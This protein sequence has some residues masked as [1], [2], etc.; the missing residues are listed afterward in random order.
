M[1]CFEISSIP[2]AGLNIPGNSIVKITQNININNINQFIKLKGNN[3]IIDGQNYEII[4]SVADYE[5]FINNSIVH[6]NCNNCIIKNI[7]I[8]NNNGSLAQYGGWLLQ[9]SF[10]TYLDNCHFLINNCSSNGVITLNSGGICGQFL[11]YGSKNSTIIFNK[12][13][14]TGPI[15]AYCGG[16]IANHNVKYSD[17]C[18][19]KFKNCYSKG[20]FDGAINSYGI[21]GPALFKHSTNCELSIENCMVL[22][23]IDSYKST[24]DMYYKIDDIGT[25]N[26]NAK[27]YNCYS[28]IQSN[29]VG[30]TYIISYFPSDD[31]A[32][33]T[34]ASELDGKLNDYNNRGADRKN[35]YMSTQWNVNYAN[36]SIGYNN[37][38]TSIEYTNEDIW[39]K[40]LSPWQLLDDNTVTVCSESN[41]PYLRFWKG[42]LY[43]DLYFNEFRK[44]PMGILKD[45]LS[46]DF[47]YITE[48]LHK[49]YNDGSTNLRIDD[50]GTTFD[51]IE[52]KNLNYLKVNTSPYCNYLFPGNYLDES[53]SINLQKNI[54]YSI[55]SD[56]NFYAIK[57]LYKVTVDNDKIYLNGLQELPIEMAD[58]ILFDLTDISNNNKDFKITTIDGSV[59]STEVTEI[60]VDGIVKFIIFN[61]NGHNDLKFGIDNSNCLITNNN[62]ELNFLDINFNGNDL[63][64]YNTMLNLSNF[65]IYNDT[66]QTSIYKYQTYPNSII[67]INYDLKAS[68]EFYINVNE[69]YIYFVGNM[70]ISGNF[71]N[72]KIYY[73][74]NQIENLSFDP[75]KYKF[76]LIKFNN[77]KKLEFENYTDADNNE[78]H[79]RFMIDSIKIKTDLDLTE[80]DD[81]NYIEYYQNISPKFPC[82]LEVVKGCTNINSANYN[83]N[84]NFNEGCT[85]CTVNV[86]ESYDINSVVDDG[87]CIINANV[88]SINSNGFINKVSSKKYINGDNIAISKNGNVLIS[89]IDNNLQYENENI[90]II[91]TEVSKEIINHEN[92][93]IKLYTFRSDLD[94]Y[95]DAQSGFSNQIF[96]WTT[97]DDNGIISAMNNNWLEN[98]NSD[99]PTTLSILKTT[100]LP[101][102]ILSFRWKVISEQ[103]DDDSL[104]I[105]IAPN[106]Q[107]NISDI[108]YRPLS[109]VYY[110]YINGDTDWAT[111]TIDLT[112]FKYFFKNGAVNDSDRLEIIWSFST[113]AS[114]SIPSL[115]KGYLDNISYTG[116]VIDTDKV[117]KLEIISDIDESLDFNIS[118]STGKL[119]INQTKSC[120]QSELVWLSGPGQYNDTN[121]IN[122]TLNNP[123]PASINWG[124]GWLVEDT[125]QAS[126]LLLGAGGMIDSK[127]ETFLNRTI[128][129]RYNKYTHL[130]NYDLYFIFDKTKPGKGYAAFTSEIYFN[131]PFKL[132]AK[133]KNSSEEKYV[134][135]FCWVYEHDRRSFNFLNT[136]D[137]FGFNTAE[138]PWI[139]PRLPIVFKNEDTEGYT[140]INH[141]S[142][143]IPDKYFY[144][145]D[146]VDD[147]GVRKADW[148]VELI[149]NSSYT[150]VE[151]MGRLVFWYLNSDSISNENMSNIL[152]EDG[153]ILKLAISNPE[154]CEEV[155]FEEE[156]IGSFGK[157]V[158][159]NINPSFVKMS[160]QLIVINRSNLNLLTNLPSEND[161]L[162]DGFSIKNNISNIV[163]NYVNN[164]DSGSS[165]FTVYFSTNDTYVSAYNSET[166]NGNGNNLFSEDAESDL[167]ASK[168]NIF[169]ILEDSTYLPGCTNS[170]AT[171][172]NDNAND[173]D[174]TCIFNSFCEDP[175]ACNYKKLGE[176]KYIVDCAGICDGNAYKDDHKNCITD[177]YV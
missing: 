94:Y 90:K 126:R 62:D 159:W 107:F 132:Y 85:G 144:G 131:L 77:I 36:S 48:H 24:I 129:G 21:C 171:N 68:I 4:I 147:S 63:S 13:Y 112:Q 169:I 52:L 127:Y 116:T 26:N 79:R 44:M 27:I 146:E 18:N 17:N 118:N 173:D 111:V 25:N 141:D 20:N 155:D 165:D 69:F 87:S 133:K 117:F 157:Y 174:G 12:C 145:L 5:G 6:F 16:I 32:V 38:S 104:S 2:E 106:R 160:D 81:S 124:S 115:N 88:S 167:L 30:N 14:S 98:T 153:S 33:H 84:A 119:N 137:I 142:E 108:G 89:T 163:K 101:D 3:I 103:T 10:G 47:C 149:L 139:Y 39:N 7:K 82:Y 55:T 105:S 150:S 86:S 78:S 166:I 170:N 135:C 114:Q 72:A 177:K 1:R 92:S 100:V 120:H 130:N 29:T 8:K 152:P 50:S 91:L 113:N 46:I 122:F 42:E 175:E 158:I 99:I 164:L 9:S 143:L 51:S 49:Y 83:S 65:K 43:F 31:I 121:S 125:R 140:S 148:G 162:F 97:S 96:E 95:L 15:G 35:N 60:E 110:Q 40:D 53:N 138:S 154:T 22:G 93:Q 59:L 41:L 61:N 156:I 70:P 34:S 58:Q 19:L 123:I 128:L 76:Y 28:L 73:G 109:S 168:G 161:S 75:L 134:E 37:D 102:G 74:D 66:N 172:Y 67:P 176:C 23:K 71:P 57:N 64:S 11:L 136:T 151:V 54:K 56:L 45:V 80:C